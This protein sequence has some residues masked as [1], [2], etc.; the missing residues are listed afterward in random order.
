MS[1]TPLAQ[2]VPN[3]DVMSFMAGTNLAFSEAVGF[4][5]KKLALSSPYSDEQLGVM[6]KVTEYSSERFGTVYLPEPNLLESKLFPRDIARGKTVVLIAHDQ[7][8]LDEYASLKDLKRESDAKGNPED[9]ELEIAKR[10]GRLLSYDETAIE[11]LI[12]KNG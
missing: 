10:F 12:A 4:G 7:S 11:R 1:D 3:F 9:M 8:V 5:V 6:M 2:I